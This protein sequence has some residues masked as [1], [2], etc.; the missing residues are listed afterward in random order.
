MNFLVKQS[1]FRFLTQQ[2]CEGD[3][4]L[5]FD[6]ENSLIGLGDQHESCRYGN[7]ISNDIY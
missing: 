4:G 5:V 2:I 1:D 7:N 6:V 3:L